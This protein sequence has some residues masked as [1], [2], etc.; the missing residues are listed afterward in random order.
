MDYQILFD[1]EQKLHHPAIRNNPVEL[2]NF[3]SLDF[4]EFGS[5]GIVYNRQEVIAA[6]VS[7]SFINIE[8]EDFKAHELASEVV[9]FTYKTKQSNSDGTTTEALRSSIWKLFGERW[10]MVFHQGTI[11]SM[12]L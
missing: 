8:A 4:L 6:L 12:S 10:Q 5:S 3:L 7:E 2:D 9:L 11:V 1:L